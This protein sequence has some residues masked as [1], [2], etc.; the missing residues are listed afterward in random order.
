[1]CE[2]PK[3]SQGYVCIRAIPELTPEV[4][5]CIVSRGLDP[6]ILIP[7]YLL[8]GPKQNGIL[9]LLQPDSSPIPVPNSLAQPV[10]MLP[11]EAAL[12]TF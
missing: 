2:S 9:T 8:S 4:P 5:Q 10:F 6:A 1:M 11:F 7:S 12:D 3:G